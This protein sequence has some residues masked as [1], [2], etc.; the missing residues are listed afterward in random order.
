M[1]AAKDTAG[2][3]SRRQRREQDAARF[4]EEFFA[5]TGF[6]PVA[7][8]REALPREFLTQSI[9]SPDELL[10]RFGDRFQLRT[11]NALQRYV[12]STVDRVGWNYDRLLDLRGFGLFSLLDVMQALHDSAAPAGS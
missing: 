12:A 2:A 4:A 5:L 3:A 7:A 9:P 10:A 6:R 8:Y 11:S 1:T